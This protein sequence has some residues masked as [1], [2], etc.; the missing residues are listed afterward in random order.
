[1][2]DICTVALTGRLT[3]DPESVETKSD[4]TLVKFGLAVNRYSN[5]E[6]AVSF[7]DV[8]SFGKTAEFINTY[9]RKGSR[10]ALDGR[11]EQDRWEKDGQ[12]RSKVQIIVNNLTSLDPKPQSDGRSSSDDEDS[13]PF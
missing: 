13:I 8:T 4:V 12:K 1:M 7:F 6:E 11:L 2:A 9:L 3:R 5:G 10:V